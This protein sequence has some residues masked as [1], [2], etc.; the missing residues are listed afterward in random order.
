MRPSHLT[1]NNKILKD[2]MRLHPDVTNPRTIK[3]YLELESKV[4]IIHGNIYSLKF[5]TYLNDGVDKIRVFCKKCHKFF[6]IRPSCLKVGQGC[7]ICGKVKNFKSVTRTHNQY[8][9]LLKKLN[10]SVEVVGI[11]KTAHTPIAHKCSL[12]GTVSKVSPNSKLKGYKNRC[13]AIGNPK[14]RSYPS[15][16]YT[17]KITKGNR[18]AYKIG[19]TTK[20]NIIGTNSE[21]RYKDWQDISA[22]TDVEYFNIETNQL[23]SEIEHY[24][25][26]TTDNRKFRGKKIFNENTGNSE[27]YC[28]PIDLKQLMLDF[29]IKSI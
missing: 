13:C 10:K 7:P 8:V 11:Y 12:C 22:I 16:I 6:R 1:L 14:F 21:S 19:I 2:K 18:V 3:S 26:R 17:F 4:K 9:K 23:A 24:Y 28:K 29:K 15:K 5:A 25:I 27:L 20:K